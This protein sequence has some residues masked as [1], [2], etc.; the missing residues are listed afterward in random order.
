[1]H[2]F[3]FYVR[4]ITERK[5]IE[6]RLKHESLRDP[7]TA[8]YNRA[9]FEEE[10]RRLD[11]ARQYPV[12]IISTDVDGLKLIN[13]CMGHQKGDELLR[14]Y[15]VVLQKT[16]RK[17]DVIARVGGDEFSVI[18][19][20]TGEEVAARL[21]RRLDEEIRL[22]RKQQPDAPIS[23]SYGTATAYGPEYSLDQMV[24]DADKDMYKDKISRTTSMENGIIGVLVSMLAAK[25]KLKEGHAARLTSLVQR[26]G[27]EIGLLPRDITDLV[28]LSEVHDLGKVCVPDEVLFK[29]DPLTKDERE[30]ARQ[31]AT[32]GY[33]IARY[34]PRLAPVAEAILYHH[35]WWDGSGYPIGL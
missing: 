5:G 20:R 12:T 13:D 11:G 34:S 2:G 28:L 17:S 31:H 33:R 3:V 14:A 18:L 7:L 10:M 23:I 24:A 8:L 29:K 1:V 4:E 9:Y 22:H 25:D 19:P 26:M 6:A 15:G 32:V 35:E 16:F 27:R 30:Q 21:G